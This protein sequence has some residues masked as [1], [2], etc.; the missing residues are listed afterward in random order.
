MKRMFWLDLEMTGLDVERCVILEVAAIVTDLE[1]R[2]LEEYTQVVH[3]PPE[4]LA[5]MD[6]WC[7][8]THGESG[9]TREVR[10]GGRP[11]PEVEDALLALVDRHFGPQE[12]VVL[13]GNSI[14]QDRRFVERHL[15]RL[16]ER[17]H[18]RMVDVSSF[19]EVFRSRWGIRWEKS[20]NHRA[21]QDTRESI[22]ELAAYLAYVRVPETK[23]GTA[24]AE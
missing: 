21:L 4:A 24:A 11:L 8:K 15:P 13:C 3:Q 14:H 18:Y 2:T 12:R 5:A 9:L 16:A 10:S 20:N 17:L 6:A 23:G 19:K 22:R 1:L 7:V